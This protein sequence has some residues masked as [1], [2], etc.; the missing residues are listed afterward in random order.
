MSE[1]DKWNKGL[2]ELSRNF[3]IDSID[4]KTSG[5]ISINIGVKVNKVRYDKKVAVGCFIYDQYD[6][7]V[8]FTGLVTGVYRPE[9]CGG[10]SWATI[11]CK[12]VLVIP[13]EDIC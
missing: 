6:S 7:I 5:Y 9:Q 12:M 8:A 10:D 1:D 11:E 13:E 4:L 3:N 2:C